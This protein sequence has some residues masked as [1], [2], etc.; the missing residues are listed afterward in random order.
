MYAAVTIIVAVLTLAAAAAVLTLRH[1][2]TARD[3]GQGVILERGPDGEMV[4]PVRGLFKGGAQNNLRPVLAITPGGIRFRAYFLKRNGPSPSWRGSMLGPP[5]SAPAWNSGAGP[6]A[7][8]CAST[9][10]RPARC[11]AGVLQAPSGGSVETT[12][13]A[14]A[15]REGVGE[16]PP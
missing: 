11:S 8:W 10:R 12:P 16:P 7:S 15:L 3:T 1:L 13:R 5:C 14:A 2:R 9:P 4:V 6:M